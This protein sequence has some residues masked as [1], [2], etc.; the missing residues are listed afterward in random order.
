[1]LLMRTKSLSRWT[2][3]PSVRSA[4]KRVNTRTQATKLS[5]Q[6]DRWETYGVVCFVVLCALAPGGYWAGWWDAALTRAL[7][8]L[9][10]LVLGG[11]DLKAESRRT[12]SVVLTALAEFQDLVERVIGV[13]R[14]AK[15]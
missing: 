6:A 10:F 2:P 5:K 13:S 11:S 3:S 1:M 8:V 7:F 4:D 15:P 14:P 12:S 9:A